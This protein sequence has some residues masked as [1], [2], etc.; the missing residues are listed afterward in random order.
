MGKP[1]GNN[2]LARWDAF[3]KWKNYFNKKFHF[4]Y[5]FVNLKKINNY[6]RFKKMFCL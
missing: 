1:K 2:C 6:E 4:K 3:L 5:L